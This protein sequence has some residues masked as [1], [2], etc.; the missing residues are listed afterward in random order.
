MLKALSDNN[1]LAVTSDPKEITSYFNDSCAFMKPA[2]EE[3]KGRERRLA[4]KHVVAFKDSK[5]KDVH[6]FELKATK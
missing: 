3:Q 4:D 2:E 6:E 1:P 5:L